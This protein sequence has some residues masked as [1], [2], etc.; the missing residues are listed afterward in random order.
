M[1]ARGES[2][3]WNGDASASVE[4]L[5]WVRP[6]HA[7]GEQERAIGAGQ[8]LGYGLDGGPLGRGGGGRIGPVVLVREM[9][10]RLGLLG[11]G[12]DALGVVEVAAADADPLGLEGGGGGVG[13]GEPGDLVPGR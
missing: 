13:A 7:R 4:G 10:D 6:G 8:R 1:P 5:P 11:A 3:P 12:P 9:N 2:G